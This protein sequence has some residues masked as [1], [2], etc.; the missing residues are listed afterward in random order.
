MPQIITNKIIQNQ[1]Q[2]DSFGFSGFLLRNL[3]ITKLVYEA[4]I[5]SEIILF[6]LRSEG[7]LIIHEFFY[8]N[9]GLI[10]ALSNIDSRNTSS[11]DLIGFTVHDKMPINDS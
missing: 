8:R 7:S 1:L 6:I 4:K 9:F 3:I 2:K 5:E 11:P 10:I